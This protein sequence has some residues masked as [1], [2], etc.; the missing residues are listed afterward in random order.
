MGDRIARKIEKAIN[1]PQGWMDHPQ[2]NQTEAT[3][4]QLEIAQILAN[5]QPDDRQTLLRMARV[6]NERF[7]A[8]GVAAPFAGI[9]KTA[10]TKRRRVKT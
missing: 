5:L 4:E 3:L 2:F 9:P 8:P 10:R 1:K 6:L 7:G